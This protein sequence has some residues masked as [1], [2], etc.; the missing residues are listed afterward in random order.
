MHL[1]NGLFIGFCRYTLRPGE[2]A[3]RI[4]IVIGERDQWGKGYGKDA[5][6]TLLRYLFREKNIGRVELDTNFSNVRARR[7]FE[8]CGF[9]TIEPAAL[10]SGE[11]NSDC[12]YEISREKFSKLPESTAMA[13]GSRQAQ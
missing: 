6:M 13:A 1:Q 10:L 4:G 11:G 8:A 2:N 9:H 12:F 5:V 3:A 7:C